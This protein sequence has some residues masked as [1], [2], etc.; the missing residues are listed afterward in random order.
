MSDTAPVHAPRWARWAIGLLVAVVAG[1]GIGWAATTALT[2]PRDVVATTAFTFVE[3]VAGEVG[4]SIN[5]NTVAQWTPVPAGFNQAAGTVTSVNVTAGQSVAV[6]ATLYT[7]NLRPVVIAQGQVPA[8]RALAQD[9][10][11]ADVTQLQQALTDLDLYTGAV[12]GKFGAGTT[13]AVKAW[14]KALGVPL[15]GVVQPGDVIFVPSLPTQV[16][17]DTEIISRGEVLIGGESVVRALPAAPVFTVPVGESQAALMPTG[18]RVEITNTDGGLWEGFVADQVVDET[19][20]IVITLTGKDGALICA[21]ACA[22]IPVTEQS[23]L[24]SRIVTV[25]SIA[26]LIVPSAALLSAADGTASVVDNA[27]T[28]HP[29][30]VVTSARGMSIIDGVADGTSVRIPATAD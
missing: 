21:D 5:L 26:G 28:S 2:P 19:G 27:G 9:A 8:F 6:G 17:L 7:V 24:S 18:T 1:A 30:T 4:S 3:V 12:D 11:G 29:V 16:A 14:Q 15:D 10:T 25:E 22:S 20:V 23:L 13:T